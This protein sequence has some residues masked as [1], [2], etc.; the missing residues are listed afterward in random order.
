MSEFPSLCCTETAPQPRPAVVLFLCPSHTQFTAES[1]ALECAL[2]L[3]L[4]LGSVPVR[5]RQV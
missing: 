1:C 2:L 5:G 3:W 4:H